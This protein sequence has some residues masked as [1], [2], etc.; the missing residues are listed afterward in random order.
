MT[1]LL[2]AIYPGDD[3]TILVANMLFQISVVILLTMLAVR[4]FLRRSPAIAHM[5]WLACLVFVAVCP[6]VVFAANRAGLSILILLPTREATVTS[7]VP[8][9]APGSL[10]EMLPAEEAHPFGDASA[11]ERFESVEYADT[12][13]SLAVSPQEY[14]GMLHSIGMF[15]LR[16]KLEDRVR[17][18]LDRGRVL[19][20]AGFEATIKL[21]DMP[22]GRC[23]TNRFVGHDQAPYEVTDRSSTAWPFRLMEHDWPPRMVTPRLSCG[24]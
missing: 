5:V 3:V 21:W 9:A 23:T 4:T 6:L 24:I 22:E 18:L 15:G 12:L 8:E 10:T 7:P 14:V 19:A 1:A 20:T 2:D 13:L 17:S 11:A 16:W